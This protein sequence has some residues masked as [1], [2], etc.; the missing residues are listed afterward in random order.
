MNIKR[1]LAGMLAASIL[2]AGAVFAEEEIMLISENPIAEEAQVFYDKVEMYGTAD[3]K[4]DGLYIIDLAEISEVQLN[5]DENTIFVDAM[6]YKTA[7]EAIEDGASLKVVASHAMTMSIPPQT[8]AHV[9]MV[10]DENGGFP[11][12]VEASKVTEDEDKNTVIS[13]KD[14]NYE[15][16]F[17]EEIT[18]IEPFATRNIVT[19]AD[20]KEGSR[21]LVT[22]G[23]MTM[24]IPAV[25]PAEKIV[26]LPELIA[27]E[28]TEETEIPETVILNGKEFKTAEIAE[29]A[30]Q[31]DGAYFLP[32]RAICEA[33][34]LEVVWDDGLKAV[35]V[36]TV[37]MGV[38]F[39]IGVNSYT[40][41]RMAHQ[42]LSAAPILVNDR[43]F[44]P[45]D[46]FTVILEAEIFAE[47][48]EVNVNL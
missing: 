44:V 14:G 25:V 29:M 28:E 3:I 46:F 7:L 47:N 35:T 13:S 38:T 19:I 4:E 10:A 43:T 8:Y 17:A 48:G 6:G 34:G 20:V 33:A 40:K 26:I 23:I 21:L 39:N 1:L 31:Q 36:G 32:V 37:P 2:S 11:I 12:Y 22:A 9:V 5:V 16:V 45:V 42:T 30:F 15:I 24:S 41:A 27:E 18:A